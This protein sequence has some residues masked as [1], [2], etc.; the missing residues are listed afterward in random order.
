[1]ARIIHLLFILSCVS[2]IA[3]IY[4]EGFDKNLNGWGHWNPPENK[5][6]Y[7][8]DKELGC[9]APGSAKILFKEG[10]SPSKRAVFMRRFPGLEPGEYR[11]SAKCRATGDAEV[12]ASLTVQAGKMVEKDGKSIWTFQ[13]KIAEIKRNLDIPTQNRGD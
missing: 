1:M 12:N 4:T 9:A 8:H 3:A 11:I 13:R 5:V 10:N 6:S 2:L 7:L